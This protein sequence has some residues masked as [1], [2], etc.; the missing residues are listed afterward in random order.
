MRYIF[1]LILFVFCSAFTHHTFFN[2]VSPNQPDRSKMVDGEI[3]V[4]LKVD[5]KAAN[6]TDDT[7]SSN[8]D[9]Y[10]AKVTPIFPDLQGIG[11]KTADPS[12]VPL[13]Q[14]YTVHFDPSLNPYEVAAQFA[15]SDLVYYAEPRYLRKLEALPNDTQYPNMA[16]FQRVQAEATWD[17]VKGQ[18]GSALIAVVDGG[19]DIS[20]ED[21]KANLWVNPKEIANNSIDDDGNGFIDD[22][23]GWNFG[24]SSNVLSQALTN[25]LAHGTH[26]S[27]TA[28]GVTDNSKGVAS[29]SWNPK[30]MAINAGSKTT[31]DAIA[32]GFEGI[33]Y[34]ANQGASI[35]SC[36]WGDAGT[37]S[38]AEYD[39]I[40]YAYSK[41]SLV[42]AAAG[43]GG[44]DGVGDNNDLNPH[45]PANYVHVL[46]VGS[47]SSQNDT[48]SGFSNYGVMVDVFAPGGSIVST[49][50]SNNYSYLSGTSM[51]TPMVSALAALVKTV[52]PNFSP[53]QLGEQIRVTAD[54]INTANPSFGKNLGGGRINALRAVSD[55][56]RPSLRLTQTTF[57]DPNA[58]QII[59]L[60]ETIT[61]N[62][63]FTNFLADAKN[64][65]ISL[66]SSDARVQILSGEQSLG[67]VVANQSATANL[68]FKTAGTFTDG[69][70]LRFFT[71]I[72]GDNGYTDREFFTLVFQPPR[73][74]NH[75]TGIITTS[76]TTRA[77]LGYNGFQDTNNGEGFKVNGR[78]LLFEGALLIGKSST[79]VSDVARGNDGSAQDNDFQPVRNSILS[80][81]SPGKK[82]FEETSL[83]LSD[84]TAPNPLFLSIKQDSY[85][86][87]Q[88]SRQGFVVVKY[89]IT[90]NSKTTLQGLRAGL[91]MDWDISKNGAT[92]F[93]KYDAG[94]KFGYV[95]DLDA[96]ATMLAGV[97]LLGK[98]TVNYRSI[99]N[100]PEIYGSGCTGCNGFRPEEK[101]Q[102]L[103]TGIQTQTVNSKDVSTIIAMDLPTIEAGKSTEVAFA[104]VGATSLTQLNAAADEA[105]RF[106]DGVITANEADS[107]LPNGFALSQNYPNPFN[108]STNFSFTLPE[109]GIVRAEVFDLL[110]KRVATL[111]NEPK[112]AGNYTLRFDATNLPSGTYFYRLT[113]EGKTNFTSTRKMVLLR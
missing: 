47:T 6:K 49:Y 85:A 92:D 73:F 51:A 82:A 75:H 91:F 53:T 25:N 38:Q 76:M 7:W 104:V 105:Q 24:Y 27:G 32:Y 87:T 28:A 45:Y 67:A 31:D 15:Q 54:A 46:A 89:T 62:L 81:T 60:G 59:E 16:Q 17:K 97:K 56:T 95:A 112:A 52:K 77:N 71:E 48:K 39:A 11:N 3:L 44:A 35:I 106:Y 102:F 66:T 22:I 36:S 14:L 21:L 94:R 109:A 78:D 40:Q 57:T 19:M 101:W 1:F 37:F 13:Q 61:T 58:N 70:T 50:P 12:I 33:V 4:R 10:Q 43:N 108:P 88:L 83:V 99:S 86:D 8:L 100:D 103:S 111:L 96:S 65:K 84:S 90:N 23:N 9:R 26:V 41:G 29:L 2:K 42:I 63:Q 64:V 113:F 34:A 72:T 20:H 98:G 5:P 80:L 107:P 68:Q 18:Q 69:E 55:F 93:A 79:Q 30:F 74:I 110:G